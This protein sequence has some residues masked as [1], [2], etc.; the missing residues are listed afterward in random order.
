MKTDFIKNLLTQAGVPE[1]K[2]KD[3]VDGIMA[4]NGKD[5]AA[6]QA[7]TQTKA[8]E[9]AAA[10]TT[11]AELRNTVKQYDGK[12]PVKLQ[13]DL[14]ALQQKYK[15]DIAAEQGKARDTVRTYTLKDALTG[16]GVLDPEVLIYK[17]GGL[18]KFAWADDKPVG[19]EETV[20]PYR[21]SNSYLFKT[22]ERKG[23]GMRHEGHKETS[24][25]G[26]DAKAE[27]NEAFRSLLRKE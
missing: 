9:L 12:D 11:I 27:A 26:N 1:D 8:T 25:G 21:E 17:H 10:N 13:A 3:I 7:K 16:L 6:E 20:K 22:E 18:D 24:V 14:D 23:W 5:L 2:H 19:L 15:D 4:E